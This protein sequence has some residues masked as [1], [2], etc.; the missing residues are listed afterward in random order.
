[1]DL[2]LLSATDVQ[3]LLD[4]DALIDALAEAFLALNG[5][6]VDAPRRNQV[7]VRD[8]G[9]LLAMPAH[10]LGREIGVKL[11]TV[12]HDNEQYGLPGHQALICLF[13]EHTGTP[14]AIMDGTSITALRTAGAAALSTR[15]LARKKARVL[16]IV[17]AGVQGRAHL[18]MLPHVR[19]FTEIRIASYRLANAEQL[20]AS[21]TRAHAVPTA[22]EAV[23]GADVVCLCTS[24]AE[25]VIQREWV[26]P[27][28]HVTSVGYRPP[29]GELPRALAEQGH[30]FVETRL[31]FEPPPVGCGELAGLDAQLGTALGEALQNLRPG[32]RS[33]EEITV[34][35]SMG[36]AAEDMAA[37]SLV[38][39]RAKEQGIG[40]LVT[41]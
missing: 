9:F 14:L 4:P 5:G 13:D 23:R 33:S 24:S 39:Q 34:Y 17:G 25:P 22:E 19:T 20:A 2:L 15:L 35:K 30:L 37:A 16:A 6:L 12:F 41:L 3:K 36:H 21:D 11:V 18:T 40:R 38:Y 7:S 31:A 27:G 1:M 32:R 10:Q 8:T 26:A 28:T 29:A